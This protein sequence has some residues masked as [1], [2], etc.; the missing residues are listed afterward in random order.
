[1]IQDN[2]Y[3]LK[4][5]KAFTTIAILEA[6]SYLALLLIAMPLKY[7][8]DIPEA[9]KYT[10]WAHGRLFVLYVTMLMACWITYRWRFLRVVTFFVGSLLPIVPF[11]IEKRLKKEYNL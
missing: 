6:I 9:V 1:M 8:M 5:V 4:L 2:T 3:N 10:G 11:I 7:F